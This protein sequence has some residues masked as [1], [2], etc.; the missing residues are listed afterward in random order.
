MFWKTGFSIF[1]AIIDC[2]I[3]GVEY[4]AKA[5]T[6]K[7]IVNWEF[8][9]NT[10]TGEKLIGQYF[11]NYQLG[12]PYTPISKSYY[13]DWPGAIL[14]GVYDKNMPSYNWRH[15]AFYRAWR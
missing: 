13:Y 2:F 10:R 3:I 5:Y 11:S 7:D 1:C 12:E 4:A 14:V 8:W 6:G 15:D 9:E